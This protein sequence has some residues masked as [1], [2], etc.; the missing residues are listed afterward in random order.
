MSLPMFETNQE[1]MGF[2]FPPPA[3][4]I[5]YWLNSWHEDKPLLDLGY[6]HDTNTI[7]ALSHGAKVVAADTNTP[8]SS[9]ASITYP[10]NCAAT[11]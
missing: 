7:E 1:G 4:Y 10:C 2:T 6:G 8:H 9:T 3:N 11:P 5:E